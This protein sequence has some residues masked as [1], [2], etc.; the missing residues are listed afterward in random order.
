VA[1]S[2]HGTEKICKVDEDDDAAVDGGRSGGR[3]LLVE[4]E[5]VGKV[6][7]GDTPAERRDFGGFAIFTFVSVLA[8]F[9]VTATLVALPD[10]LLLLYTGA[11]W[12]P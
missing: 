6:D 7:D 5:E 2:R 4:A 1:G 8:G 3:W 9:L 10:E 11:V 12:A